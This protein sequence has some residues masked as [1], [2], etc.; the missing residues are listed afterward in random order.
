VSNEVI[1]ALIALVGV[2]ITVLGGVLTAQIQKARE[3]VGVPNGNGTVVQMLE[4][5]L[6]LLRDQAS[7]LTHLEQDYDHLEE[8]LEKLRRTVRGEEGGG[9]R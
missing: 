1:V 2:V 6:G 3:A 7:R 5:V 8:D 4:T 9:A